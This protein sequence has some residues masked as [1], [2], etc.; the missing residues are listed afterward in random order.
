MKK[1][2]WEEAC[3]L[4]GVGGDFSGVKEEHWL[5]G[6]RGE[7]ESFLTHGPRWTPFLPFLSLWCELPQAVQRPPVS[8]MSPQ[9]PE[10]EPGGLCT[11]SL[12][13]TYPPPGLQLLPAAPRQAQLSAPR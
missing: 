4:Q 6:W 11:L 7:M 3:S 13:H 2:A 1:A 12:T 8:G 10:C 5:E 9:G